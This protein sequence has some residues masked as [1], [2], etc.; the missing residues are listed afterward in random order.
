MAFVTGASRG[1]GEYVVYELA[2]RG[3]AVA[4]LGRSSRESPHS[5]LRGTIE[6]TAER[7]RSYGVEVLALQG[8][9]SHEDDIVEAQRAIMS[10]FG[11]CDILVNNA[12]VVYLGQFL[13]QSLK[14]WKV[15][16]DVN[17]LG[18]VLTCQA[19]LP[20]MLARRTGHIINITS[21]AAHPPDPATQPGTVPMPYAASKAALNR[22]TVGLAHELQGTGVSV[23][24]LAV[25]AI[26]E[27]HNLPSVNERAD[28]PAQLVAWL[29]TQP[30]SFTGNVLDQG[31]LLTDLR[32]RG[33]VRPWVSPR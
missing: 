5:R 14:R 21:A 10:R 24:A 12:A 4:L 8:D 11:H 7:A 15:V 31:D 23:N 13:E 26:T 28:A 29:A 22:L 32:Q 9:V 18:P 2:S 6:E 20:D 27:R 1:I 3:A 25:E 30:A 19:F 33:I 16:L 17:I